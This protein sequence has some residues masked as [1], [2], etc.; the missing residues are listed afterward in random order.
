[1]RF[2]LAL[3]LFLS[4]AAAE[5]KFIIYLHSD[6][7][8]QVVSYMNIDQ[9]NAPVCKCVLPDGQTKTFAANQIR[10]IHKLINDVPT[11]SAQQTPKT[12]AIPADSEA[13]RLQALREKEAK[14][15]A[16]RNAAFDALSPEEKRRRNALTIA[17][18]RVRIADL[19]AKRDALP[20]GQ[21]RAN[22]DH[23]IQMG[24]KGTAAL[25]EKYSLTPEELSN[26]DKEVAARQIA[27]AEKV[28]A[29]QEALARSKGLTVEQWR[30]KMAIEADEAERRWKMEN[31]PRAGT[32]EFNH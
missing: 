9:D 10:S 15:A 20:Y 21:D 16:E 19:T 17:Y 27:A 32:R 3:P 18:G 13:T 25:I 11:A 22:L 8:V 1:M 24:I 29:N 30:N 14:N 12:T 23:Q 28:R 26:A 7:N 4:I 2:L 5:P 6:E 31:T